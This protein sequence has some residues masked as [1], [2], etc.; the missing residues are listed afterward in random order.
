M[1][2]LTNTNHIPSLLGDYLVHDD[3]DLE[4]VTDD[5]SYST[6]KIIIFSIFP[7]LSSLLCMPCTT[8]HSTLKIILPGVKTGMVEQAV[9]MICQEG[10]IH[11]MEKILGLSDKED[12]CSEAGFLLAQDDNLVPGSDI[13]EHQVKTEKNTEDPVDGTEN[14]LHGIEVNNF[15]P[16]ADLKSLDELEFKDHVNIDSET[17]VQQ[18]TEKGSTNSCDICGKTMAPSKLKKHMVQ[19]H[20]KLRKCNVCGAEFY[21]RGDWSL[22]IKTCFYTCD[23]CDFKE[24]RL[25]RYEGHQR[26]HIRE[27]YIN[28]EDKSYTQRITVIYK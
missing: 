28:K 22:H 21:E 13:P 4:L 17:S 19:I 2:T 11:N 26:R 25:S 9:R 1:L 6:H 16:N 20:S 27:K 23:H 15:D 12:K 10:N 3:P 18:N 14:N 5:G 7:S 8:T 24:K